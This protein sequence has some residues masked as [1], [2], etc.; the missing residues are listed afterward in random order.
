MVAGSLPI[1]WKDKT[2]FA[3]SFGGKHPI[4]PVPNKAS[5][6]SGRKGVGV[7]LC[8]LN[9]IHNIDVYSLCV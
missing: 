6:L 4:N 1:P 5:T 9:H 8:I 3:A 2:A 7:R